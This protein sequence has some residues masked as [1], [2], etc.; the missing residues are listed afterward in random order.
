MDDVY[1]V[2]DIK[3]MK[4]VHVQKRR[5]QLLYLDAVVRTKKL[6]TVLTF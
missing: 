3:T 6:S 2:L 1:K 4:K 5:S